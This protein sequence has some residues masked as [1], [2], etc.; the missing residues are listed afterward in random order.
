MSSRADREAAETER[1]VSVVVPVY[2]AQD[3][4]EEAVRSAV[5]LPRVRE[6]IVVEDGSTD[7]SLR[8]CR[9]L[10]AESEKVLLLRHPDGANRGPSAS[11]NLGIGRASGTYVACL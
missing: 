7:H 6:V 1:V 8:V 11:R 5:R 2:N 9:T 4:V 10:A 3:Y